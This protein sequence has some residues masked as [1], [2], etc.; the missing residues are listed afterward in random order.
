MKDKGN[1]FSSTAVVV[2]TLVLIIAVVVGGYQLGWWLKEDSVNRNAQIN[3]D[4]YNRQ[5]ALVEQIL[6]DIR[7]VE[8]GGLPDSQRKAIIA[9]ICDSADKLTGTVPVGANAEQFIAVNC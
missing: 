1:I 2:V 8:Q 3:Q 5:N 6:D 4:S 7:E 9:Q